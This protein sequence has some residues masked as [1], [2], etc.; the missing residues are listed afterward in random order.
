MLYRELKPK[1]ILNF[2]EFYNTL[3]KKTKI[4]TDYLVL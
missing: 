3:N 1:T 2:M 4:T